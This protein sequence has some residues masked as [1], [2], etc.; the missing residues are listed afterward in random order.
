MAGFR[1]PF[2]SV[3][4]SHSSMGDFEK[5]PRLYF[6][7]NVYKQLPE[8][9]KIQ[10]V[11]PYL[12]LG[13]AVHD[14]LESIRYLPKDIRFNTPL[15]EIYEQL[16]QSISGKMG[17]FASEIQE[18]E[19][20][21][22][23]LEMVKRVQ[24]SPGPIANLSTIIKTKGEMVANM[25]LSEPDGLIL[26]GNVDWV[27]V[28]PDGSLHIID[29]K[30]GKHEE[31]ESS[32]QL[33]IYLMLAQNG[34]KRPVTKLSYW[35]LDKDDQ[36]KEIPIPDLD[37]VREKLIEKGKSIK[38]ARQGEIVCPKGGCRYCL[39]YE[40]VLEGKTERVGYDEKREKIL[41]FL[42]K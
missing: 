42:E 16:W 20:K 17:G 31:S 39:E 24:N 15:T 13:I 18:T 25:W 8:K 21:N 4:L 33:Q 27:E 11:N 22:R 19:F 9:K 34:N 12:S 41:Y 1:Y 35:Y 10:V 28:L 26:C 38:K 14:T 36:P 37:G 23:G 29:F 6:L 5:C 30:T 3:W 2:G 40:R 32:L 7:R